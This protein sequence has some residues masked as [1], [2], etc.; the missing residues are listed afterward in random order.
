MTAR[1]EFLALHV[2]G[3]P[4]IMP[5]AWDLGS[6]RLFAS[7]GY[8]AVATTSA[9]H[10]A[11]LGR[12]D[13]GVTPE[14]A[15]AHGAELAGG[16]DVPVSADLENGFAD[17]AGGVA[18]V[19]AAAAASGLAG[20]SI[21]DW[22]PVDGRIY[23]ARHA[24]AR[25]AAAAAAASGRLVLTARAENHIRGVDDLGDTIERLRAYQEAGADVLFAPGV[26][27]PD[28]VRRLVAA[29]DLP[30]NVLLRPGGP[31]VKELADAGA[32]RISVGGAF[33][34]TA[35]GAA[36]R[37]ARELLGTGR[38]PFGEQDAEGAAIFRGSLREG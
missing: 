25:V 10:A 4:L 1:D 5:N 21:E 19:V 31:S 37:A 20:C 27:A 33:A 2:P 15:L 18:E 9:G 35:Y 12:T 24:T 28:D 34:F 30:L 11:T 23:D 22:T 38:H 13:G 32:A 26:L 3:R 29:V 6:A 17:D 14:E 36:A 16:V 7:L 8:Q